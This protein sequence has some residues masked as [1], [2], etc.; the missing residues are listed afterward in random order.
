ML[1]YVLANHTAKDLAVWGADPKVT[2]IYFNQA[3]RPS[4]AQLADVER[5]ILRRR[6]DTAVVLKADDDRRWWLDILP[7]LPSHRRLHLHYSGKELPAQLRELS[8]LNT[9][10]RLNLNTWAI[11]D[12]SVLADL[13][14]TVQ[15][16]ELGD[17]KGRKKGLQALKRLPRL[18]QLS[19]SGPIDDVASLSVL[20]SIEQ[21]NFQSQKMDDLKWLKPLK[22]LR[23]MRLA[24]GTIKSL[25]G[26]EALQHL[27]YLEL[28][29][30][31]GVSDLKP[32]AALRALDHLFLQTIPDVEKLPDMSMMEGLRTLRLTQMKRLRD[33]KGMLKAPNLLRMAYVDVETRFEPKD[34]AY[35]TR[36]PTLEA[37]WV[38]WKTNHSK[39]RAMQQIVRASGKSADAPAHWRMT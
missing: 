20:T 36:H 31:R 18:T 1:A 11:R 26:I 16:I 5:E 9:L 24:L 39:T 29:F 2:G 33:L 10:H 32:I 21:L 30:V 28:W 4:D 17:T 38:S 15:W 12:V 34:L 14:R 8:A 35:L 6:P 7:W 23:E 3:E 22:K 19:V 37:L 25:R 13:P 27:T